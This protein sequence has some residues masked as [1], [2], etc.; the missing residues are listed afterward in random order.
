VA[1]IR[2]GLRRLRGI[3][4]QPELL[5]KTLGN[6][7][8]AAG[9]GLLLQAVA[10]RTPV[11]VDGPGAAACALLAHRIARPARTWLQSTDGGADPLHD[12]VLSE[13]RLPPLTQFRLKATIGDDESA[14]LDVA[15]EQPRPTSADGTGARV[16]LFL[17]ETAVARSLAGCLQEDPDA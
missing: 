2:D 4:N 10:R 8:L 16:A 5:L 12:R 14:P 15:S 9:T 1:A 11:F 13:L 17:L 3:H 6:P 7:A